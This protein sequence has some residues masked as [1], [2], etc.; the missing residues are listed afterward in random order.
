MTDAKGCPADEKVT[1]AYLVPE[2]TRLDITGLDSHA[3]LTVVRDDIY[4][5]IEDFQIDTNLLALDSI[6]IDSDGKVKTDNLEM[7]VTNKNFGNGKDKSTLID[8]YLRFWGKI[9]QFLAIRDCKDVKKGLGVFALMDI[10]PHVFLGIY[11][12]ISRI[13]IDGWN[14]ENPYTMHTESLDVDE[15][16]VDGENITFSNFTRFINHSK[17]GNCRCTLELNGAMLFTTAPIKK[18]DELLFDYGD[19]YWEN[20]SDM[21]ESEK[22]D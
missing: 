2:P 16:I 1:R 10:D 21:I 13:T 19:S 20:R 14:F 4:K 17:N 18:G 9:P 3:N 22:H 5:N 15:A 12:G 6:V 8:R 11:Q 7:F